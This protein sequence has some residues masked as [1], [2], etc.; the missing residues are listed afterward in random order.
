MSGKRGIK[1]RKLII[2]EK[3]GKNGKVIREAIS[4]RSTFP[5][6]RKREIRDRSSFSQSV[7]HSVIHPTN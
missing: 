1:A 3:G 2:I 5:G 4:R 7:T 6:Y